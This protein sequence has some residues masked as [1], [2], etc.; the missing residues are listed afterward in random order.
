MIAMAK[1]MQWFDQTDLT[2]LINSSVSTTNHPFSSY[3]FNAIG[4]MHS[5][6]I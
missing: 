4:Q 2:L 1:A 5:L 6:P 3:A